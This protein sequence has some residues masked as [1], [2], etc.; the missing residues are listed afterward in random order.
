MPSQLTMFGVEPEPEAAFN[1]Y[2][3][4]SG[5]YAGR[6]GERW[7][8]HG[9]LL[10]PASKQEEVFTILQQ[11]RQE[12][13]Y[14]EEVHYIKLRS[15]VHG[16]KASCGRKWLHLYGTYLSDFCYYHCLAVDTWSPAFE[17]ERFSAPQYAYNR[18]ARM[19]VEGAIAWSLKK[20]SR[21]ALRFYSDSKFRIEGDNFADYL[22]RQVV[23]SLTKKRQKKPSAYPA[24]RLL[25][26]Q[27]IGVESNPRKAEPELLKESEL[28]QL[29][30]LLT[31]NIA[32]ALT[33]RSS[34]KAK[35]A[36]AEMVAKW[37]DD[38]KKPPWL[39]TRELHRRF[40]VSCFP[41]SRGRFYDPALAMANKGQK[42][43]FD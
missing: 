12:T 2:H 4:E 8:L 32:Q 6:G 39:Q 33:G 30:D 23:T 19:A 5:T 24:V 27:V 13:G 36:L 29:V 1:V 7:L 9:V 11:A 40:S 14:W 16:P 18:F 26:P 22:P 41:D 37:I 31:S 20:Y 25:H 43:F 17:H 3:D 35:I 38:V 42:S 28:I 15:S 21:V 34:Q 10:V